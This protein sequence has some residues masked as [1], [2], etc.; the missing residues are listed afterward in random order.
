MNDRSFLKGQ[1]RMQQYLF[2]HF[3]SEYHSALKTLPLHLVMKLNLN[4]L[5][6]RNTFGGIHLD[7]CQR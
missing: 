4:V 6:N 1:A 5:N 7:E 3:S 2:E